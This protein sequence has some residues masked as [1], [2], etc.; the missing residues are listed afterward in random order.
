MNF[1][2]WNSYLINSVI[3]F[4]FIIFISAVYFVANDRYS[5]FIQY[6]NFEDNGNFVQVSTVDDALLYQE[7]RYVLF[8][9]SPQ[10]VWSQKVASALYETTSEVPVK[11]VY[12]DSQSVIKKEYEDLQKALAIETIPVI[13]LIEN[14]EVIDNMYSQEWSNQGIYDDE[15]ASF[16]LDIVKQF[17]TQQEKSSE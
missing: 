2:N 12:F 16:N 1:K 17:L 10:S 3:F 9:G 13:L 11:V 14:R 5:V 7:D 6:Y 4:T 15:N 8:I